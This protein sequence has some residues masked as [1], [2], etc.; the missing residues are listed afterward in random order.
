MYLLDLTLRLET[1]LA[2]LPAEFHDR[3]AGYLRR[4]PWSLVYQRL[5]AMRE[6]KKCR[7]CYTSC[8]GFVE[9]MSGAPRRRPWREFLGD[10][11]NPA[12]PS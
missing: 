11:A 4:V 2:K 8:R 7:D 1:G 3:H 12:R 10:F 6:P 5:C 9:E